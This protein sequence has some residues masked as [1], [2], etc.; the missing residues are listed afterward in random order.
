MDQQSKNY[1]KILYENIKYRYKAKEDGVVLNEEEGE[2]QALRRG[3][4]ISRVRRRMR[5][6]MRKK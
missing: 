1:K 4:L 5:K 3:S 2:K 6:R